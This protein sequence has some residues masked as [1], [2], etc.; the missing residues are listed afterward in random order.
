MYEMDTNYVMFS[1]KMKVTCS[2]NCYVLNN[3]FFINFHVL[4]FFFFTIVLIFK[5]MCE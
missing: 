4:F 2:S 5:N 1:P 3:I